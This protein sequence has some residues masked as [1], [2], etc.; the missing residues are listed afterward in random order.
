MLILLKYTISVTFNVFIKLCYYHHYV[1]LEHFYHFKK[2]PKNK[3]E[4]LYIC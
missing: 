2:K 3:K 1:I 4:K